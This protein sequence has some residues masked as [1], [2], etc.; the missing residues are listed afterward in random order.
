MAG[1]GARVI[2]NEGSFAP[3]PL[4]KFRF[5]WHSGLREYL[6]P[7]RLLPYSPPMKRLSRFLA[8]A[9]A[10]VLAASAV[11]AAEWTEDYAGALAQAKKEHKMVL[12]NFTGSDW[13][14]WCQRIDKEVLDTQKF[15]DFADQNL[16]LVRLDYPREH[17]QADAIKAQN[18]SLQDK[19]GIEAF[20]MLIV[21]SPTGKVVF[22]QEGYKP[23]GPEAFLAQFPK[24]AS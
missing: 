17:P 1:I 14:P 9:L 16:I 23:G 18:A 7:P 2:N 10:L 6:S 11:R 22:T 19:Y 21:L 4:A 12:L 20:P 3:C 5:L 13:C 15:K 24:P 8:C